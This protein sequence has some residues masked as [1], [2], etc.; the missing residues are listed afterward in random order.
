VEGLGVRAPEP[1]A[2]T[3]YRVHWNRWSGAAAIP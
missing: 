2:Y 1:I 3:L